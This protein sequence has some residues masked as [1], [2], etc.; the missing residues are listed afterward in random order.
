MG[1]AADPIGLDGCNMFGA[2]LEVLGWVEFL[3]VIL[4]LEPSSLLLRRVNGI[5]RELI[6]QKKSDG[7]SNF[8]IRK[9]IYL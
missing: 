8:A 5:L 7:K 6:Q 9:A 1:K 3:L 4:D 2:I